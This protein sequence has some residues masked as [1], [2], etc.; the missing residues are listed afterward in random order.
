MKKKSSFK[1]GVFAAQNEIIKALDEYLAKTPEP[2]DS[3]R[4]GVRQGFI[5]GLNKALRSTWGVMQQ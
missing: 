4:A 5:D 2:N 3:Y 1:D